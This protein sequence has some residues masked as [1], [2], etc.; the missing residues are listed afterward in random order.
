MLRA[1]D[2][3][4]DGRF[5]RAERFGLYL[6]L[7]LACAAITSAIFYALGSTIV[8][9]HWLV[10]LDEQL[11]SWLHAH[12]HANPWLTKALFAATDMHGTFGILAMTSFAALAFARRGYWYWLSALIA[13]VPAGMLLNVALK[14][15]YARARPSFEQPFITLDTYSFPSGHVS[16]STLLYGFL[17]I[18]AASRLRSAA[19]R[20]AVGVVAFAMIVLV[21]FSRMYLGAHYLTDVIAAFAAASTWLALVLTFTHLAWRLRN[22]QRRSG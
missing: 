6:A 10:V 7:G 17:A 3:S 15:A 4:A 5:S 21:A 22:R 1:S 12:A 19:A 8:P 13:S 18:F 2:G 20:A 9:G 14:H 11:A 16:A